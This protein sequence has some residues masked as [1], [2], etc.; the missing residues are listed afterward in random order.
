VTLEDQ[1]RS[2]WDHK[3]IEEGLGLVETALRLGRVGNYQ[4]QAAIAAVHAEAKTAD[5]TDWPQ[6]VALY[7]EL[8]RINSSPIVAL[9]H[10][11]A[12]AMSEGL[13]RGLSLLEEAGAS[14]ELDHY[15]LFHASRADL[16]RRLNRLQEAATA[17][18]RALSLATNEVE[19][20]YIRKRLI[21]VT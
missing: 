9:N 13:E 7:K 3:E 15:Y 20:Q 1:D 6:I 2:R 8:M 10:A 5:E 19:Q 4:L 11:A 21:E 18:T 12:V 14:G 16:L 17:Y